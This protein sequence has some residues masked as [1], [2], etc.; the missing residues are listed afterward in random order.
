MS[1]YWVWNACWKSRSNTPPAWLSI[2][3]RKELRAGWQRKPKD[4]IIHRQCRGIFAEQGEVETFALSQRIRQLGSNVEYLAETVKLVNAGS[5]WSKI[6]QNGIIDSG[7]LR[8]ESHHAIAKIGC[9]PR[10]NPYLRLQ[11][12]MESVIQHRNTVVYI[13]EGVFVWRTNT[14][15]WEFGHYSATDWNAKS[16]HMVGRL[17]KPLIPTIGGYVKNPIS[18]AAV[19]CICAI[20]PLLQYENPVYIRHVATVNL[21]IFRNRQFF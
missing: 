20:A 3:S 21:L 6:F 14:C 9:V 11:I 12:N 5:T 2:T 13:L 17:K 10:G 18:L 1:S 16:R 19:Y 4:Q 7:H 8:C 15:I